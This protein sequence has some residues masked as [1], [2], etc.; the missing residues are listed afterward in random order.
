MTFCNKF[1]KKYLFI[2]YFFLPPSSHWFSFLSFFLPSHFISFLFFLLLSPVIRYYP[3]LFFSLPFPFIFFLSILVLSS[4]YYPFVLIS[5]FFSITHSY[6]FSARQL[7]F[8]QQEKATVEIQQSGLSHCKWS[9][10]SD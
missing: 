8:V 9:C 1:D 7:S 2:I 10:L 6:Y 5:L 3:L 4:H